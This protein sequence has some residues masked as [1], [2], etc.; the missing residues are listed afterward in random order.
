MTDP[1]ARA[2]RGRWHA[3]ED[4]LYPTL[5]A[6][7]TGYQRALTDIQSVVAELRRRGEDPA[8]LLAAEAAP[9]ELLAAAGVTSG[10]VPVDLLVGVACG[11]RDRELAAAREHQ[12]VREV[13]DTARARGEDWA[14]VHGPAALT[15]LGDGSRTELHLP[16][17][18]VLTAGVDPWSGGPPFSFGVLPEG[19]AETTRTFTD[20]QAWLDEYQRARAAVAAGDPVYSTDPSAGPASEL[21]GRPEAS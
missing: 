14:T 5:I 15:E 8:V 3:A 4:R 13:V 1:E 12:R 2:A 11:T 9:D 17:G 16:S 21:A 20:R 6:N 19:G 7:P 18:A 10:T